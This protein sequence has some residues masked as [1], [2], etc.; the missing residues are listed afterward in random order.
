MFLEMILARCVIIAAG[1]HARKGES[2][3]ARASFAMVVEF[4]SVIL[5]LFT[6]K[7]AARGHPSFM[8]IWSGH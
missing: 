4:G 6:A 8:L 3:A 2:R 5:K 7:L 1:M